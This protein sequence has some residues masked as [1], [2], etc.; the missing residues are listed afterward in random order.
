MTLKADIRFELPAV[1]G[2]SV[3]S[4][5]QFIKDTLDFCREYESGQQ[6]FIIRTS[7]STGIPKEITV[8]GNQLRASALMTVKALKLNKGD[9]ALVCLNTALIAG[10]MMLVRGIES[11]MKMTAIPPVSNPLVHFPDDIQFDFTAMVPYQL[12]TILE[13]TPE[14]S[15]TLSR[16]KAI[17]VGGAPVSEIL[18]EKLQVINAPVYS[19]YGMTETVSHIALRKLNGKDRSEIFTVLPGIE[20]SADERKCLIIKGAVTSDKE[21]VTNDVVEII[22]PGKFIW[23]GRA[24]NVI[25]SGGIKI[26]PE[27]LEKKIGSVF[28]QLNISNRFYIAGISDKSFG[29]IVALFI[30]GELAETTKEKFSGIM[31]KE[32]IKY[33]IPKKIIITDRFQETSSGK[34]DRIKT[35]EQSCN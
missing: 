18:E 7:G 3:N 12:Q 35:T 23:R 17:I 14:K 33:E 30:E 25:N 2:N 9:H 29:T 32:F 34:I 28:R 16:M 22:E 15:R 10:K 24:D 4:N 1:Q 6:N 27:D 26:H 19:T 11:E 21:I 20:I 13:Q 31:N 8:T 5:E